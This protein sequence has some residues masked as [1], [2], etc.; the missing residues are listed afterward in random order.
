[1]ENELVTG[2]GDGIENVVGGGT[3][4]AGTAVEEAVELNDQGG[5]VGVRVDCIDGIVGCRGMK[6]GCKGLRTDGVG[7]RVLKL[8]SADI[9]PLVWLLPPE[10]DDANVLDAWSGVM[11]REVG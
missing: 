9:E 1:M 6:L 3:L 5:G 8:L 11:A 10:L 4:L 7:V 2:C